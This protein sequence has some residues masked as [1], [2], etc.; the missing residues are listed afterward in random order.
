MTEFLRCVTFRR[1]NT[2]QVRKRIGS[3]EH[4]GRTIKLGDADRK[5]VK[6]IQQRLQE[7][8]CGPTDALGTFGSRTL[9]SVKLFQARN[10]DARGV[11]LK[12]DGRVGALTWAA[13]FGADSL[14]AR[15]E[16]G[17][18]FLSAVL[19]LPDCLFQ[20]E[21]AT[22]LKQRTEVDEYLRCAGVDANCITS[23]SSFA[24]DGYDTGECRLTLWSRSRC[25][26]RFPESTGDPPAV[27]P[28]A[29][30]RRPTPRIHSTTYR[31]L[32]G[33]AGRTPPASHGL[34][35]WV[36]VAIPPRS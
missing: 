16:S 9:A 4:P 6:A 32:V 24:K 14:P 1:V 2:G 19:A 26:S 21:D 10:V 18:A 27:A 17:S 34:S 23:V 11:P 12:Q 35:L 5:T 36:A 20:C 8:G 29:T 28:C 25:R 31:F 22:E 3:V 30:G 7:F 33:T 15:S 13:L